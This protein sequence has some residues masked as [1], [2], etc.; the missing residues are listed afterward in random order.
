MSQKQTVRILH[1]GDIH[2]DSPFSR[3]SLEQSEERRGHL[4]EAFSSLMATVREKEIDIALIA[5]DLFDCAYVT[6]GTAALLIDELAACPRCRFFISPGN[7]DPYTETSLYAAGRLPEN[8]HVFKEQALSSV[9]LPVL[10]AVVWG[11]AFTSERYEGAPLAGQRV[12]DPTA[13]NLICGHGDVGVPL[14]PYGAISAADLSAFGA[15]YAALGHRHLQ[16]TPT[17]VEGGCCWAYCGCLEGRSFDE[18]G[19]GGAWLVTAEREAGG[20]WSLTHERITLSSRRYAIATID[21]TGVTTQSEV[22]RRIKLVIGAEGY[23][24]DTSLRVILT[25]ATPPDFAVPRTANGKAWGLYYMELI[26]QTIPTYDAALLDQDM[27]VRGE[28]YRSLLPKLTSGTPEE[29]SI[30]TRALRM[31][32]AAL[33]GNDITTL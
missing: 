21:L 8:V 31:G 24:E 33:A 14:S 20:A 32:L 3:L 6:A 25:G 23:D 13:L 29:R 26:D 28:L 9:A 5:G 16:P 22:A 4:R 15:V 27:T 30:A 11:W 10:D 18:P 7:H 17:T 1:T 12:S 19:T 2:L